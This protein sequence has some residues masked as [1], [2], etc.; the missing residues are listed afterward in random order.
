MCIRDSDKG[1]QNFKEEKQEKKKEKSTQEID[2]IKIE[3]YLAFCSQNTYEK[4]NLTNPSIYFYFQGQNQD[5]PNEGNKQQLLYNF[6]AEIIDSQKI[7]YEYNFTANDQIYTSDIKEVSKEQ[8]VHNTINQTYMSFDTISKISGTFQSCLLY[9][10][11]SPR[12]QA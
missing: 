4:Q 2:T 7:F 8:L 10:S 12:D 6:K 3:F 5:K 11:P 1:S 9:T